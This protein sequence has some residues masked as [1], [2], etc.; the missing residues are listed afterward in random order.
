MEEDYKLR[1]SDFIPAT[2]LVDYEERA[3]NKTTKLDKKEINKRYLFLVG[4]NSSIFI[5]TA[6]GLMKGLE[7][8]F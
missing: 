4:Y 1:K 2:G 7:K 5:G 6:F 8:I 3:Y